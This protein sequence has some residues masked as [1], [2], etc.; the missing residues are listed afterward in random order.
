VSDNVEKRFEP[1]IYIYTYKH[2]HTHTLHLDEA[3]GGELE[4][5]GEI[6]SIS[7]GNGIYYCLIS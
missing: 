4:C 1:D 2:T 7:S 3:K 6:R 5:D